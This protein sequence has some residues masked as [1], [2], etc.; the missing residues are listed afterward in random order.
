MNL[1][2]KSVEID[3][4]TFLVTELPARVMLPLVGKIAEADKNQEAQ[5][6]M[7]NAAISVN[8]QQID[9]GELGMTAFMKLMPIVQEL[10]GMTGGDEGND[11][12]PE[13]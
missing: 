3:G 2:S 13:G 7:M 4:T 9:A 12:Q 5:M 10:N 8:G 6:Q 11:L 1:K